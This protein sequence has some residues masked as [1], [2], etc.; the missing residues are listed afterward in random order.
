MRLLYK[1]QAYIIITIFPQNFIKFW[2]EARTKGYN[3]M[4]FIEKVSISFGYP[5]FRWDAEVQ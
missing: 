1:E 4:Y 3:L 5:N 2:I